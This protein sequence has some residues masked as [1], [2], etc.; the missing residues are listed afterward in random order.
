MR[1]LAELGTDEARAIEG[2]FFDLDDTLLTYGSLS[3][4]AYGAL[5]DLHDA[6]IKL[7]PV[8]GR[9]SGW[10]EVLVRQWPV[11]GAVT[12]NGAVFVVREGHGVRVLGDGSDAA[13]AARRERLDELVVAVR[14]SLPEV[15]LADDVRARRSDVAWDIGE[16]VKL[17]E[18]RI[19]E[20]ARLVV[21][22]GARMTRSSVHLHASY[23][24]D[25]KASGAMR[26]VRER[27]GEDPG[28]AIFR[29]AFA[30]DSSNDAACFA[31]LR[32]TFGVANVRA[33]VPKLSVPPRFVARAERGDGFAEIVHTLL[34]RRRR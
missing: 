30:G 25:D 11:D 34:D 31:G 26:F 4:N 1:P 10:A 14:A 23:E 32:T 29:W 2:L 27:F 6:G 3:R 33:F 9:P 28:R 19:A 13:I 22:H 8:T 16:R 21:A 18:A 15:E 12:E 24:R 7:V 17:S 20:L 5:W